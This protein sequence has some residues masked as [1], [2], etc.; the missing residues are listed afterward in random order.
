M[1]CLWLSLPLPVA[2]NNVIIWGI[3]ELHCKNY[4]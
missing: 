1:T 3:G 4:A 2:E